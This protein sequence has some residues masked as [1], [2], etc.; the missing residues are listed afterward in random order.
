MSKTVAATEFPPTVVEFLEEVAQHREEVIVMK[1]GRELARVV[2]AADRRRRT[3][4]ELRAEGV[5]ILGDIVE[6]IGE[7][8]MAE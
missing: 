3:L 8:E 7:W 4:E 5:K 6:P 2:P 1:D